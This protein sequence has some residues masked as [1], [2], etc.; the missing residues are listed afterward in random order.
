MAR[1][2]RKLDK[3]GNDTYSRVFRGRD[4]EAQSVVAMKVFRNDQTEEVG[5]PPSAIR[6]ISIL[7]SV[8]HASIV[9]FLDVV[10]ESNGLTLVMEF[11]KHNLRLLLCSPQPL[12][13]DLV[14]SYAFQLLA[15][16]AYLHDLGIVHNNIRPKNLLLTRSGMLKV[17]SFDHAQMLWHW[18]PEHVALD[19]GVP[20][21]RP[22]EELV[23]APVIPE[24]VDVWSAGCVIAEMVRRGPLSPGDSSVDEFFKIASMMGIPPADEW[25]ELYEVAAQQ[26]LNIQARPAAFLTEWEGAEPE[27]VNF[28]LKMLEMDPKKR[29]SARELLTHQY[30]NRVSPGLRGICTP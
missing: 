29:A 8:H 22:P 12:S 13:P 10:H 1:S 15:C 4:T 27:L 11:V 14:R 25:P 2:Y 19:C 26:G 16:L 9:T 28:L 17:C 6:E 7:K 21:Y 5:L 23:G 18:A 24:K 3:L 30:F 20:W